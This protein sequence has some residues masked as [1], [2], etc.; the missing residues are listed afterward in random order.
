MYPTP[1]TLTKSKNDEKLDKG[2]VKNKLCRNPTRTK[3]D[4]HEFKKALF[5][6]GNLKEFL[7]F[8]WNFQM[9]LEATGALTSS[10]KIQYMCTLL[11]VKAIHRI[12]T[13]YVELVSTT[14]TH[15]N[16]II[17]DLGTYF[18]P[19]DEFPPQKSDAPRNEEAA[20]IK[21][22]MLR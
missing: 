17:L 21:S 7:L 12:F 5:D 10:A 13:L 18:F 9:T 14:T 3:L 22:D 4:L 19:I 15:V 20:Q 2:S 11:H 8:T 1:I 16:R 6:N